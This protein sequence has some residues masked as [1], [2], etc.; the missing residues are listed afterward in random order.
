[1][2]ADPES[3]SSAIDA[4]D[5]KS[6]SRQSK[7]W[8]RR[9]AN[10]R[11]ELIVPYIILTLLIAMVGTFVVTRLV[12]SSIRERFVNQIVEASRVAAD[13]VVRQEQKNLAALRLLVF[14]E[15]VAQ[16]LA[17]RD[18]ATLQKLL[19]PLA[20]N[21]R[22]EV[23]TAV[24]RDGREVLTLAYDP[25]TKQYQ[26]SSGADF[27]NVDLVTNALARPDRCHR[28][29]ICRVVVYTARTLS[30]HQCARP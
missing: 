19:L 8:L 24:D 29:Q 12:T 5:P 13:G 26:S 17:Q 6:Q 21:N 11:T 30:L 9:L 10:L 18:A 2:E 16:A 15:G 25:Q 3:V 4:R 14:T 22:S 7:R 1:M 23:I 28:R 20:L 27:S